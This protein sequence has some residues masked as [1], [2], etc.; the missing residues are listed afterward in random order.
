MARN[1]AS[2]LRWARTD[3]ETGEPITSWEQ[4]ENSHAWRAAVQASP[5]LSQA[6]ITSATPA[7]GGRTQPVVSLPQTAE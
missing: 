7:H 4:L 3:I 1:A 5:Q 2:S 6:S